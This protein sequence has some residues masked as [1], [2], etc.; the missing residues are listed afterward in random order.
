MATQTENLGLIKPDAAEGYDINVFNGNADAIDKFAGEMRNMLGGTG[1]GLGEKV[2]ALQES[3]TAARSEIAAVKTDTA[4]LVQALAQANANIATLLTQTKGVKEI[5]YGNATVT[6]SDSSGQVTANIPN[7][8]NPERVVIITTSRSSI[9]D[10]V[11]WNRNGRTVTFSAVNY[12]QI[13]FQFV[14]FY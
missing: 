12:T 3:M 4:A 6:G 2:D 14:E 5:F 8:M 11:T 13:T 10:N 1:G 9:G 7:T